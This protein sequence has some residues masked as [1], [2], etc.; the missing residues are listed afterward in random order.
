LRAATPSYAYLQ[1]REARRAP[2]AQIL[3]QFQQWYLSEP[4]RTADVGFSTES[5][6]TSSR[7][8][9]PIAKRWRT[10]SIGSSTWAC[11]AGVRAGGAVI[12]GK[13]TLTELCLSIGPLART[14]AGIATGMSL[15]A[16]GWTLASRPARVVGRL[17]IDGVDADVEDLID[18][19]LDAARLMVR[20]IHLPGCDATYDA[21]R[22]IIVG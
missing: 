8:T 18:T 16:P 20:G 2:T 11:L 19:A 13:T 9:R 21:L 17:R 4:Y 22:T 12:A 5:S 15:I 1:V 14:V 6:T 10:L 3:L 7:W